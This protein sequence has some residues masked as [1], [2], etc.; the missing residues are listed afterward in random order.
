MKE[1]VILIHQ[2][3]VWSESDFLLA[4]ASMQGGSSSII[5]S[6]KRYQYEIGNMLPRELSDCV[7]V[8]RYMRYPFEIRHVPTGRVIPMDLL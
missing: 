8:A 2:T 6:T 5:S 7:K 4:S 3:E 1:W